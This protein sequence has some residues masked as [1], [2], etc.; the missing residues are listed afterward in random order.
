[1]KFSNVFCDFL[2]FFFA[3][4]P[5]QL[6]QEENRTDL[7]DAGKMTPR[8][9]GRPPDPRSSST[10]AGSASG[11]SD[12][13]HSKGQKQIGF[14]TEGIKFFF[15]FWEDFFWF[16][17]RFMATDGLSWMGMGGLSLMG[18]G[19]L[20]LMGMGGLS[21]MGM[22]GLT[23]MGLGGL[24]LMGMGGLSLMGMGGLSLMGMGGLSLMGMGGLSLMGMGGLSLMTPPIPIQLTPPIPIKVSPSAA[25]NRKKYKEK[26]S[27]QKMKKTWYLR[28]RIQSVFVP[29]NVTDRKSCW[30]IRWWWRRI[31]GPVAVRPCVVS[32]SRH[33]WDRYDSLPGA[34]AL[35]GIQRKKQGSQKRRLKISFNEEFLVVL[36][37]K[38]S[39]SVQI[40]IVI[41][42]GKRNWVLIPTENRQKIKVQTRNPILN[43][44]VLTDNFPW[45]H[46]AEPWVAR[47]KKPENLPVIQIQQPT[48]S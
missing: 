39:M 11:S 1:M 18:M 17:F 5:V 16:F 48:D 41:R 37:K 34:V 26:N 23:W 20:S 12:Q 4:F 40:S 21:L 47:V 2:A 30:R 3:F 46:R 29:W 32:S 7:T 42:K 25:I 28:W 13:S 15:I 45:H 43:G 14:A 35:E 38:S 24:T 33:P 22:G 6:L 8:T 44:T 9:D 31:G 10:I 36:R 19:G 27:S